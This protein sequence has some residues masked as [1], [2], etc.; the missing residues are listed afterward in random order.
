M[1]I[2]SQT[3]DGG[4]DLRLVDQRT[5]RVVD[6]WPLPS[7]RWWAPGGEGKGEVGEAFVRHGDRLI[8]DLLV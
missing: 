6:V 1:W 4:G 2:F 5:A 7:G 3:R 8:V